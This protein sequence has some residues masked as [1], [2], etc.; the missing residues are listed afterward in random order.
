[1]SQ[2]ELLTQLRDARPAAP[3]E[4]RERV[5]LIAAQAP[6][7]RRRV[8]VQRILLVAVPVAVAAIVASVVIPRGHKQA[9]TTLPVES[10]G[11]AP[12]AVAQGADRAAAPS[13]PTPSGTR[14]QRYSASLSLRVRNAAA[15]SDG[16][17]KAVAIA[18]SLSGY[19]QSVSVNAGGT[20]GYATI[21]LRIP[22]PRIQQ[23]VSR[24]SALGTILNESVSVQDLQAGVNA[25]DRLIARLQRQLAALR[26]KPQTAD[27]ARLIQ[28]L[29]ARIQRLQRSQAA[30]A[31]AAHYATVSLQLTSREPAAPAHQ[32]HGPLHG[33]GLAFRWIGIGLLYALALG[34][35]LVLLVLTAWLLARTARRRREERLLSR[36]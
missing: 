29:T 20:T 4:V 33:L 14:L 9:L 8:T 7:P 11:A 1:M 27:T 21:V 19:L 6:P 30:T 24:L 3:A 2:P 26:A 13:L 34:T 12:A 15:V 25:T 32:G 31:R 18:Q 10:K 22:R 23:A 5:R 16:T 28:A 17:K 36:P 35:P